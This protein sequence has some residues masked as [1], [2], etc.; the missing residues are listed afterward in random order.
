MGGKGGENVGG[1]FLEEGVRR[2]GLCGRSITYSGT[3]KNGHLSRGRASLALNVMT[4]SQMGDHSP[5]EDGCNEDVVAPSCRQHIPRSADVRIVAVV[6]RVANM[7]KI[8]AHILEFFRHLAACDQSV[9]FGIDTSCA[10]DISSALPR[11]PV[12]E[13]LYSDPR[14]QYRLPA[15]ASGCVTK[16]S[17]KRQNDLVVV[18]LGCCIWPEF[19]P[20]CM[21]CLCHLPTASS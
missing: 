4:I 18:H 9:N 1:I 20:D 8:L 3:H 17:Y 14:L 16:T 5:D 15:S 12:D 19:F 10:C 7:T 6:C 11:K 2:S 13:T 21:R